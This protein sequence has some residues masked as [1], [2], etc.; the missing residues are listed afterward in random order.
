MA[1]F[2]LNGHTDA[3]DGP[4]ELPAPGL[5]LHR[6]QCPAEEPS[7]SDEHFVRG[8]VGSVEVF[9]RFTTA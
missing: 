4:S 6:S 9:H 3:A 5:L 8:K 7:G 1:T 2:G